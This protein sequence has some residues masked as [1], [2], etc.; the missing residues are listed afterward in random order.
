MDKKM[1]KRLEAA[2]WKFGDTIDFLGLTPEESA[3]V[4]LKLALSRSLRLERD[5]QGVTQAVLAKLIGSSQ[6]RVA[7][8]EAGDPSVT[9]DLLMRALLA[10]GLTKRELSKIVAKADVI[11]TSA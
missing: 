10:L 9:V 6:S 5:K 4:E 3:F 1:M 7:K 2:G 11:A 8:M